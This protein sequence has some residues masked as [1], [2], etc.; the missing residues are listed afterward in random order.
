[1]H[2]TPNF[3]IKMFVYPLYCGGENYA[4]VVATGKKLF[5]RGLRNMMVSYSVED[6]K[7][8]AQNNALLNNT[9]SEIMASID[10]ILVKHNV[11]FSYLKAQSAV[12]ST[13][14]S[15]YVAL[16]PAGLMPD[17]VTALKEYNN[18]QYKQLWE[19]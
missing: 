15:G 8:D 14:I 1:M 6:T 9:V 7:G 16:K 12:A 18:S 5:D 13:P 11:N 3:L 10:K 2:F 4:E 19:K 17:A